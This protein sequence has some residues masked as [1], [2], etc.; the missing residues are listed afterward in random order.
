MK[1]KGISLN[2]MAG[3]YDIL[4]P[5]EKSRRRK[6]QIDLIGLKEG[7]TVLEVGCGTGVLSVL[8]KIKTGDKGEVHGIDI[9]EKMII[10]A[11]KKAAKYNLKINF[12][13]A[14]I[15]DLPF[16]DNYFNVVISSL[17]FHHLPVEVKEAGL[18]EIYRVLNAD[19][20]FLLSDFGSP[21]I[22]T[23]PLMTLLL[24]WLSSTRYQL[25][26]KLPGLIRKA[27]FT[28]IR[29]VKKELFIKHY[30]IKK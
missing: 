14:S 26:G 15:D 7:E 18:S 17:M 20:R 16:P 13:V 3:Y 29:L 23:A 19:G 6:K 27:G 8:S 5:A 9:A 28:N 10:Q 11:G 24:I 22:F 25:F 30:L 1:S 2:S 4:T 12:K 21:N